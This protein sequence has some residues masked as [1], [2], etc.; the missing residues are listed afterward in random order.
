MFLVSTKVPLIIFKGQRLQED[1]ITRD[2]G[3]PG[4]TYAVTDS[5]MMQ[6]SVFFAF[7]RRFHKH[8]VDNG[9]V[10]GK[11]HIIVLD[12]HASHLTLEVIKFAMDNNLVIFQL[13]SHSSHLTQPLDVCAFGIFKRRS[14]E[15]LQHW[16]KTHGN[17]VP[18]KADMNEIIRK[19]WSQAFTPSNVVASFEGSGLWPVDPD[20]AIYRLKGRGTKRKDREGARPPLGDIPIISSETQLAA[21]VGDRGLRQLRDNGYSLTGLRVGT[22]MFGEFLKVQQSVT[23]PATNRSAKGVANGGVLTRDEVLTELEEGTRKKQAE[24]AAKAARKA[25]REAKRS[26]A[27]RKRAE[28]AHTSGRGGSRGRGGR[29]RGIR[30]R[31]G[32]GW[33]SRTLTD[34]CLSPGSGSEGSGSTSQ[35]PSTPASISQSQAGSPIPADEGTQASNSALGTVSPNL[36]SRVKE[37]LFG[38][39][40]SRSLSPATHVTECS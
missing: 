31:G 29:G 26:E 17:K 30:G 33:D 19:S 37:L 16:A 20:R 24:E 3:V 8:L 28:R 36:I 22:V 18:V 23:R 12:G 40:W 39:Y 9:K 1:W 34:M 7:F 10:D 4:A 32:R 6:G 27:E 14:T 11:P 13:P 15:V 38:K 2:T 21:A 35:S 5:S 25:A